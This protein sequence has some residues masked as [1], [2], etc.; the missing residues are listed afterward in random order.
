ML[1]YLLSTPILIVPVLAAIIIAI[2]VHEF[3]HALAAERLGDNT[4]KNLG[5]LTLNP[6][7]H[8]HPM[9]FVLLLLVGFGWGNP[10]PYD[11]RNL[12]KPKRDALLIGLAGPF[13]N[14]ILAI[15]G[16]VI[17]VI[18]SKYGLTPNS[19]LAIFLGF[20]VQFNIILMIFNLLPIPPL[21]GSKLLFAIIPDK[22]HHLQQKLAMYGPM[23]LLGILVFDYITPYSI[24]G[25]IFSFFLNG[26]ERLIL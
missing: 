23:L 1:F 6:M 26:I 20:L 9:G 4:A 17:M 5:R 14:L 15:L 18:L 12:K 25:T 7:S 24:F 16:I 22:Y 2:T 19:L 10:V 11:E 3:S 8:I 21:D 13:S